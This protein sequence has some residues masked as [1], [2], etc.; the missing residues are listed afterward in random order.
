MTSLNLYKKLLYLLPV[1]V[2]AGIFFHATPKANASFP[3]EPGIFDNS[4]PANQSGRYNPSC[5]S[6]TNDCYTSGQTVTPYY[7]IGNNKQDYAYAWM[8]TAV[9]VDKSQGPITITIDNAAPDCHSASG[10][11]VVGPDYDLGS[12]PPSAFDLYDATG[13]VAQ[14]VISSGGCFATLTFTVNA[15][16]AINMNTPT[17]D[18]NGYFNIIANVMPSPNEGE[19][20]YRVKVDNGAAGYIG[21]SN[22]AGFGFRDIDLNNG[23]H[24]NAW[25]A[26]GVPLNCSDINGGTTFYG[27]IAYQDSDVSHRDWNTNQIFELQAQKVNPDGTVT[28]NSWAIYKGARVTQGGNML[29]NGTLFSDVFDR[30]YRYRVV[31]ANSGVRNTLR[32]SMSSGLQGVY[33]SLGERPSTQTCKTTD[34]ATCTIALNPASN[35][36]PNSTVAVTITATNTGDTT[37]DSTYYMKRVGPNVINLQNVTGKVPPNPPNNTFKF[38]DSVTAPG[39]GGSKTIT[40]RMYNATGAF[41]SSCQATITVPGNAHLVQTGCSTTQ[42]INLPYSTTHTVPYQS[43]WHFVC[44][45]GEPPCQPI[46]G[47][48]PPCGVKGGHWDPTISY[49]EDPNYFVDIELRFHG[50]DNIDQTFRAPIP[51]DGSHATSKIYNT[52]A[53]FIPNNV[54]LYPHISYTVDLWAIVTGSYGSNGNPPGDPTHQEGPYQIEQYTVNG[55]P[56]NTSICMQV[57]QCQVSPKFTPPSPEPGEP[58]NVKYGMTLSNM[59]GYKYP[60]GTYTVLLEAI[61]PG[62][63]EFGNPPIQQ[64]PFPA[65]A[66]PPWDAGLET[67]FTVDSNVRVWFSGYLKAH[68]L[69][70]GTTLASN[71]DNSLVYG[72]TQALPCQS[73]DYTPYTRPYIKVYQGDVS[74]GGGFA[75]KNGTCPSAT[76][77]TSFIGPS[78]RE[79]D[80]AKYYG[81]IRTYSYPGTGYPSS[82]P[83]FSTPASSPKGSSVEYGALA[84][85]LIQGGDTPDPLAYGFYSDSHNPSTDSTKNYSALDFANSNQLGGLLGGGNTFSDAHCAPNFFD[86]GAKTSNPRWCSSNATVD[87]DSLLLGGDCNTIPGQY[88]YDGTLT[89]HATRSLGVTKS[90]TIFVKGSVYID[91]NITYGP[92]NFYTDPTQSN[93]GTNTMPYLT[94][95]ASGNINVAPGV[96]RID[97]L[98]IAQ[99]GAGGD[100]I[101]STCSPNGPGG[102][103]ANNKQTSELCQKQLTINGGVIAK[104]F[105]PLRSNGTLWQAAGN[106]LPP[107]GCPPP[108]CNIAEIINFTPSIAIGKANLRLS[109]LMV[110]APVQGIFSL[111]PVF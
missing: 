46:H 101:F 43:G 84:L 9:Y 40:Y 76:D 3:P 80:T 34:N 41:G 71:I 11:G 104:H 24:L 103:P 38:T 56:N 111:P 87:P 91:Q 36:A 105:Y 44:S 66:G 72:Q 20:S 16:R 32:F 5:T 21:G 53:D 110:S 45:P 59:T 90:Y 27:S 62:S 7:V 33:A 108:T 48:C 83:P 65:R 58:A 4:S 57:T 95:V 78:S 68:L 52:F 63:M 29:Q 25:A 18:F 47:S 10:G 98:Y 39:A 8:T 99:P 92:W 37:W 49:R 73:T 28:G 23:N 79:G 64:Q 106:E 50:S 102:L 74:T 12:A 96:D 14:K 77:P 82:F 54:H 81:G 88:F 61:G 51:G 86:L 97:G 31:M 17:V 2:I 67:N 94:V 75:D 35:W 13:L 89:I 42:V 107:P 19:N 1:F 26:F 55:A 70:Q 69:F 15:S 30:N 100:G 93:F 85:G 109:N 6:P 60:F 22:I